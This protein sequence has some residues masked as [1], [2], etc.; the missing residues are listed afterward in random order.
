MQPP[1]ESTEPAEPTDAIEGAEGAEGAP[2]AAA[3]DGD[4]EGEGAEAEAGGRKRAADE[5]PKEDVRARK[6]NARMFG[7]LMGTLQRFR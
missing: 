7:A 4:G 2:P 6:R 3:M 5:P 1:A